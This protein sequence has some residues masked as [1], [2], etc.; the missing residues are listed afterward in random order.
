MNDITREWTQ[1]KGTNRT[2]TWRQEYTVNGIT[3][4]VDGKHVVLRPTRQEREAAVILSGKYGKHVEFVPQVIFPQGV[5]TPDYMIDGDRFDL[6][7]PIGK[8]K[9]VIDGLIAKKRKQADN[10]II[11]I[12]DC[13]LSVEEIERQ[14]ERLYISPRL[15]FL[16]MIVLMKNMDVLKVYGRK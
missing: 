16:E 2:V 5:Q 1:T 9:N 14:I 15:G 12:S 7:S 11:D 8:G 3:Y 6:K 13:P 4:K 10:F